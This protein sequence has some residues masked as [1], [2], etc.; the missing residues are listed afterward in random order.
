MRQ[1]HIDLLAPLAHA[2]ADKTRGAGLLATDATNLPILDPE[3]PQGIR[4]GTLWAWTNALWVSFVYS[5]DAK[6]RERQAVSRRRQL[7][8]HRASRRADGTNPLT[9]IERAGVSAQAVGRMRVEGWCYALVPEIASHSKAP[10]SSRRCS[11][12]SAS[13]SSLATMQHSARSGGRRR[14]SNS[15]KACPT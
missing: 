3:D 15:A 13:P 4:S 6:R 12:S 14:A 10:E 9:F 11:P 2:I 1:A 7:R 8:A 5:P